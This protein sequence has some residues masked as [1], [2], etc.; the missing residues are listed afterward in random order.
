M[1]M[2][3]IFSGGEGVQVMKRANLRK[4]NCAAAGAIF[5]AGILCGCAQRNYLT[6]RTTPARAELKDTEIAVPA[7][8]VEV[9]N[10][11]PAGPGEPIVLPVEVTGTWTFTVP[12]TV[13]QV[14][15][16]E[17]DVDRF[18][19]YNGRPAAM[20]TPFVVITVARD[21]KSIAEGD[22]AT[23]KISAQRDYAMNGNVVHE[24]TGL[25]A[26][27][28][29]FSELM[30]RQPGAAAGGSGEAAETCHAMAVVKTADEQKTAQGILGSIVW[31]ASGR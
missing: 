6:L 30:I 23:Y 8:H 31:R 14:E 19:L 18:S 13:T 28:A 26:T 15:Q 7:P 2:L 29:A 4:C 24:W 5:A 20:D 17:G 1:K 25:T 3:C 12:R 22:A 27:G 9:V 16:Q 10:P 21:Q 11:N